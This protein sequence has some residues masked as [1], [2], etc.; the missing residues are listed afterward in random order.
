MRHAGPAGLP[1]S[2]NWLIGE[3]FRSIVSILLGPLTSFIDCLVLV[4]LPVVGDGL[5]KGV[6]A[7]RG[8]HEGLDGEKHGLDL[9]GG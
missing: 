9:E 8:G 6:I 2:S 7:V 3:R 5:I 4:V 1:P